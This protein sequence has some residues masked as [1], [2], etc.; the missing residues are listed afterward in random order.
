VSAAYARSLYR[1]FA[2]EAEQKD[3]VVIGGGPGGYVAAIKAAQLGMKVTC[4][5]M[6]GKLGGTCLNVG[7][8]PSKAL[9]NASHK[10]HEAKDGTFASFGIKTGPV[11][12]DIG[13]LMKYKEKAVN[14]LTS[15]IEMLFKKNKVEY[16]KGKGKIVGPNSVEV[17]LNEGGGKQ[18]IQTKNILIATG[19]DIM[20]L[21]NLK[22]DEETII[23]ST[24]A[25]A[26]KTVPKKM[27]VIGGG[28]IGLELGSVWARLGSE[29]TV[30]EFTDRIAAGA[31][32]EIAKQFQKLLEKQHLKFHLSTKVTGV[33]KGPNGH[34]ITTESAGE[35]GLSGKIEAD[36]VLVSVG[37]R[38][39]TDGLGL[40]QVGVKID[41]KKRVEVNDHF[42]TSVPSIYAIGDVIRGPMLAHKGEDEGLAVAEYLKN[43]G[44]HVNYG[45][46]PSVIYTHPEVAWVGQ[47]EEELKQKGV[48]Y[49]VGKFPF[50]GNSRAKTNDE[51]AGMVKFLADKETDRILGVHIMGPMAGEL[52]GEC[53]LAIEYGASSEDIARVC[54]AHPTLSEAVKEAAM[55][56]YDKPIH[57]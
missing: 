39:Y 23:S 27:V 6:R 35:G 2:T 7:C 14:G 41:G 48:S 46:I 30:V 54:H 21:P 56:A 19:S 24:G 57:V 10:Y 5:E 44:G 25:L 51:P 20:S 28:V 16:V 47:T 36:V 45:A 22:I 8:I 9:L 43:G 17:T 33:T 49:R 50:A 3:L 32:G 15:G 26:L 11:E 42:Q 40:D 4:V 13:G 18:T 38:P 55:A 53:V 52:I 29:V 34:V 37:R 1:G 12:M 31:D